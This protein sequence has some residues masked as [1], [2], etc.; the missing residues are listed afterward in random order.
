LGFNS[1]TTLGGLAGM[2]ASGATG[3]LLTGL[4]VG[5]QGPQINASVAGVSIPGFGVALQA[6]ASAGDANVLSTPHLIASDNVEAEISVGENVPLQTSSFGGLGSLAGLGGAAGQTGALGA[7]GGLGAMGGL[8]GF[9]GTVPRDNV[10][11]TV[12]ITPHL[13]DASEIRLTISEEIGRTERLRQLGRALD[14]PNQSED[15]GRGARPADGRDRRLD[16]RS[17]L[18]VAQQD[19]DP[20]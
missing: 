6:L 14:Q 17:G 4:A 8:G 10:G 18:H 9:G 15:R 5:V 1:K 12:T 11:T 16:A 13:N 3:D 2:V 19:P 7:L 20:R